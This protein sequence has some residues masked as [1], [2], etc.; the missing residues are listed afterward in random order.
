MLV[1]DSHLA[2]EIKAPWE[3]R[4]GKRAR[5]CV[6]KVGEF[7]SFRGKSV[8]ARRNGGTSRADLAR[9]T[10][11]FAKFRSVHGRG[12]DGFGVE[13]GVQRVEIE[14]F[15]WKRVDVETNRHKRT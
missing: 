14:V 6:R 2:K 8:S 13:N 10:E 4:G 15:D 9:F 1:T 3:V 5:N 11:D 7:A 12:E